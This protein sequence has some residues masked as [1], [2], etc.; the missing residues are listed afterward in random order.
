MN[1][2]HGTPR[3]HRS[4]RRPPPGRPQ[5]IHQDAH[6][7]HEHVQVLL[8][9]RRRSPYGNRLRRSRCCFPQKHQRHLSRLA[10]SALPNSGYRPG[11]NRKRG[12]FCDGMAYHHAFL[13][14]KRRLWFWVPCTVDTSSNVRHRAR[15]RSGSPRSFGCILEREGGRVGMI[16]LKPRK[17]HDADPPS[18]AADWA[19]NTDRRP[20]HDCG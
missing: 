4:I 8:S 13:A 2:R 9:G 12:I 6:L 14:D 15:R 19:R 3:N 10:T 20:P 17:L 7:P 5:R 16:Y 18:A 11:T 1:L